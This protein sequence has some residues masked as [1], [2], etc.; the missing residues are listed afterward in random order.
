MNRQGAKELGVETLQYL[1]G[2]SALHNQEDLGALG[3]FGVSAVH[4]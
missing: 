3:V 1:R 4:F 2:I